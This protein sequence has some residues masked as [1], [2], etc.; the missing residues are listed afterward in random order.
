MRHVLTESGHKKDM[1][2]LESQIKRGWIIKKSSILHAGE[3]WSGDSLNFDM[4]ALI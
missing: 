2:V 1:S 3:N 4:N